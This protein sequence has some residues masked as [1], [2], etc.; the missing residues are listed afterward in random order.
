MRRFAL[1][2]ACGAVLVLSACTYYESPAV[3]AVPTA[4]YY[5]SNYDRAFTAAAGAMRDQGLAINIE[6]RAAGTI[7]GTRDGMT[8]TANVRAQSDGS[9]RL[10]FDSYSA[11]DRELIERISQGY[12]R[13]MGR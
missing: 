11:R 1:G 8:I 12:D 5:P 10:Q 2:A 9:V 13:R 7:M 6:D 3:V 4:T